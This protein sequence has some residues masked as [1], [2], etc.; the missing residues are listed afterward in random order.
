[1]PLT[2]RPGEGQ[3]DFGYALTRIGGQRKRVAF[4]VTSL[5]HSDAMFAMAFPH[6]PHVPRF[7]ASPSR[8]SSFAPQRGHL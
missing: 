6:F 1:M 2:Q 8:A 4:F 3:V 7:P 5:V